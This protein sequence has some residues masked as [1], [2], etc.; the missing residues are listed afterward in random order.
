MYLPGSN[1]WYDLTNT[2]RFDQEDGR[3]RIAK[4]TLYPPKSGAGQYVTVNAS[5]EQSLPP[6]FVKAGSIVPLVDPSVDVV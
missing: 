4:A 2:V 1:G 6:L 3:F 5:L